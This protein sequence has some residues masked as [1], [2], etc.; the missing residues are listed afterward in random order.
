VKIWTVPNAPPLSWKLILADLRSFERYLIEK[1]EAPPARAKRAARNMGRK[2]KNKQ[3]E[4][5]GRR[6][7]PLF[8]PDP[9]NKET[10]EP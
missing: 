5:K 3:L 9:N 2:M 10:W 6:P 1:W 4:R 7:K 8:D